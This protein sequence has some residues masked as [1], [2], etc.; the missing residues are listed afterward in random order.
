MG[1]ELSGNF[2]AVRPNLP[3]MKFFPAMKRTSETPPIIE[4]R[5]KQA[6]ILM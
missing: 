4:H 2:R 6:K 3:L 1:A 5:R